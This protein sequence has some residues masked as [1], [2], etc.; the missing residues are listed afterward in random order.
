MGG[1]LRQDLLLEASLWEDGPLQRAHFSHIGSLL[2]GPESQTC[3]HS[4]LLSGLCPC[5]FE[6]PV[7]HR[8]RTAI[9]FIQRHT[10]PLAGASAD[11]HLLVFCTEIESVYFSSWVGVFGLCSGLFLSAGLGLLSHFSH[12]RIL[13]SEDTLLMCVLCRFEPSEGTLISPALP[14]SENTQA[15]ARAVWEM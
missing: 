13:P 8:G 7:I 15:C 14:S 1:S 3:G 9:V 11:F 6:A 5:D 4:F 2:S 10:V 12:L